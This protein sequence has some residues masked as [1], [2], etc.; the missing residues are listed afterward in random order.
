[1]SDINK[2]RNRVNS[3]AQGLFASASLLDDGSTAIPFDSTLLFLSVKE[4]DDE[5]TSLANEFNLSKTFVDIRAIVLTDVKVQSELTEFVAS[6]SPT[7]AFP[8][9]SLYLALQDNNKC[10]VIAS[11]VLSADDLDERELKTALLQVALTA[12]FLDDELQ[13]QYGGERFADQ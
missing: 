5:L 4:I 11:S 3:L 7:D 9:V 6:F 13:K 10:N 12:N 1:M 2:I 8:G